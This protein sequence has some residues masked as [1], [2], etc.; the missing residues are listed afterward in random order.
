MDNLHEEELEDFLKWYWKEIDGKPYSMSI[1]DVIN[2][3]KEDL[4]K[5][6]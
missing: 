4:E 3:Y 2:W 5:N 6:K 1:D